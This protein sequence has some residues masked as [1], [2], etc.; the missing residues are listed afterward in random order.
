[1]FQPQ[2]QIKNLWFVKWRQVHN[3]MYTFSKGVSRYAKLLC[4]FSF[5]SCISEVDIFQMDTPMGIFSNAYTYPGLTKKTLFFFEKKKTSRSFALF[6]RYSGP[7][8]W[9][10]VYAADVGCL[11]WIQVLANKVMT[12]SPFAKC[13]WWTEWSKKRTNLRRFTWRFLSSLTLKRLCC[14]PSWSCNS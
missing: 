12:F 14:L 5:T 8:F 2:N 3:D 7:T 9:K 11:S 13:F 6:S 1:M 4:A 10:G